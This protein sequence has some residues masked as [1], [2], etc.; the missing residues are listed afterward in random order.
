MKKEI[1]FFHEGSMNVA[2]NLAQDRE[3]SMVDLHQDQSTAFPVSKFRCRNILTFF[4]VFSTTVEIL[5]SIRRWINIQIS[6]TVEISTLFWWLSKYSYVFQRFFD[7]RRNID[8]DSTLNQHPNFNNCRNFNAFLMTVKIFLRFSML[9]RQPSKFQRQFNVES[10]SKMNAGFGHHLTRENWMICWADLAQ[11]IIG[12]IPVWHSYSHSNMTAPTKSLY[13]FLEY[14]LD[15]GSI[16]NRRVDNIIRE[17]PRRI[18]TIIPALSFSNTLLVSPS[19]Y[20]YIYPLRIKYRW[21]LL[22]TG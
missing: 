17:L 3:F 1:S 16:T 18:S 9:F 12:L 20:I 8:V 13:L 4:N 11:T 14:L 6:T 21:F 10:M 7:N 15:K 22:L 5:T 2:T 19:Y